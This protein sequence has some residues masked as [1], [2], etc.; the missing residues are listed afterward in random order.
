MHP[1]PHPVHTLSNSAAAFSAYLPLDCTLCAGVRF[2][3]FSTRPSIDALG[4]PM[5]GYDSPHNKAGWQVKD[6]YPE[7]EVGWKVPQL[8]APTGHPKSKGV[9]SPWDHSPS[10]Y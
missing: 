7:A 10:S 9:P 4:Y 5:W 6:E 3:M 2:A 1:S 8:Y